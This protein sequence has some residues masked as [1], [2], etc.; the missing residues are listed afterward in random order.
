MSELN[1][2]FISAGSF[3]REALIKLNEL[4]S[5]ATLIA[6][7]QNEKLIGSLTD[8]DIRRGLIKGFTL[9]HKI[10][11]VIEKNP[12]FILKGDPD[13]KKVLNYRENG[14]R[15]L[16]VVDKDTRVIN[17]VDFGKLRSYLPIDAVIM[18]GGKGQRLLPLTEKTPKPLLK[19][20]NK[21]I[22]EH[23]L[24]RLAL[25][26]I[27]DFWISINYLG[28]QIQSYFGDGMAKNIQI[29]Y[30]KEDHFLGTIGGLSLIRDFKHDYIL[31]TNS[32]V[33]TNFDYE[34]FYLDFI[35]SKSDLLVATIKYDVN[36]PYAVLQTE[37]K[38]IKGFQEKPTY[39]YLANAGIYLMRRSLVK[40]IP[41]NQPYNATDF[42]DD[43]IKKGFNVHSFSIRDYWLDIGKHNDYKKAQEDIESI[44][45]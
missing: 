43:L 40:E 13:I 19:I 28:D 41:I 8:G 2:H 25:Y 20:G 44:K 21:P 34:Q 38:T 5:G 39:T 7:D 22:L 35:N 29:S 10:D 26:G 24:D 3:I 36:I 6:V 27:V 9:E 23:N 17:V 32:D 14:I 45:F 12:R 15:I 11:E 31:L 16:P 18:A 4:S 30:V 1:K 33:L 42:I 37:N